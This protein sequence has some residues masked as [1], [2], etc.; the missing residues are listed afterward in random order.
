[1]INILRKHALD[2]QKFED[3]KAAEFLKLLKQS[4]IEIAGRLAG[5]SESFT[6]VHL[7][8]ILAE[9]KASIQG[10]ELRAVGFYQ[11][12]TIEAVDLGIQHT[13]DEITRLGKLAGDPVALPAVSLEAASGLSDPAQALLANHFEASVQ[14]Y[15]IDVLNSVRQRIQLGMVTGAPKRN[16]VLDVKQAIDGQKWKAEQI[17]R[18]ETSHAYGAAQHRSIKEAAKKVPGMKKVWI[19]QSSYKCEVCIDLDGTERPMDGTWEIKIGRKTKKVAH[20]PA[21]PNCTCRVVAMKP[22]WRKALGKLGYL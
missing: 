22:S 13:V 9:V 18:T 6:Q 19:H 8:R 21:H 17:V 11:N 10:L 1:M 7:L 14:R 2:V 16:V 5:T 12:A 20:A 3:K 15:G 4:E